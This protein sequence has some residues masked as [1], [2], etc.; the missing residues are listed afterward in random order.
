MWSSGRFWHPHRR[1]LC[2]I[3]AQ[4]THQNTTTNKMGYTH[5]CSYV[6]RTRRSHSLLHTWQRTVCAVLYLSFL[7][8]PWT[9]SISVHRQWVTTGQFCPPPQD[10]W[11]CLET[12]WVV[13][14]RRWGE[15]Y[16]HP[17]GRLQGC[18]QTSYNAQDSPHNKGS[19][20]PNVNTAK[21][22]APWATKEVC[23]LLIFVQAL[24]KQ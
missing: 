20:A 7:R 1:G 21:A 9:D 18:C 19:S 24:D 4:G 13:T 22:G 5:V 14:T 23:D 15:C 8:I 11:H 2:L 16:C 12:F 3:P 10:I 17:V 6:K